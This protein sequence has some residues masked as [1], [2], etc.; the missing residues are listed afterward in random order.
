MQAHDNSPLLKLATSTGPVTN[1]T[2]TPWETDFTGLAEKLKTPTIGAKHGAYFIR[3]SGTR[4][5]DKTVSQTGC[6]IILD[7]D[8]RIDPVTGEVL[9]GAPDPMLVHQVLARLGVPHIL[10]TSHSNGKSKAEVAAD[11]AAEQARH[12]KAIAEGKKHKLT[13][14]NTGGAYGK[15]FHKYRVVIP[16]EVARADLERIVAW[17]I[18]RLHAADVML[19]NVK[20]NKVWPQPWFL[21]RVPDEARLALFR[22]Y[23]TEP[24]L[25]AVPSPDELAT[26]EPE[27]EPAP[28]AAPEP[29]DATPE[30]VFS[31]DVETVAAPGWVSPI[32]MFNER[33]TCAYVLGKADYVGDEVHGWTRP[34]SET[35]Q[36]GVKLLPD[37]TEQ[38]GRQY[39]FS[40]GNDALNDGKPHDAFDCYR[41][42]G[43]DGDRAEAL[44][45]NPELSAANR[46]AL[47][48][49]SYFGPA[50]TPISVEEAMS[51]AL[52]ALAGIKA[53]KEMDP[54][55]LL[56]PKLIGWL[57]VVKHHDAPNW[58]RLEAQ[59]REMTKGKPGLA[60]AIIK[61]VDICNRD[62]KV[63]VEKARA[64][65]MPVQPAAYAYPRTV[66]PMFAVEVVNEKGDVAMR[67]SNVIA[68]TVP[69]Y[70]QGL[71]A[72]D[73]RI[74]MWYLFDGK[75]WALQD[76]THGATGVFVDLLDMGGG[77]K[78]G[79]GADYVSSVTKITEASGRLPLPVFSQSSLPFQNGILDMK[80]GTLAP[81]TPA[82]ALSFVLPYG[83]D[84]AAVY[85][86]IQAWL[87]AA[88]DG[89][90]EMVHFLLCMAAAVLRRIM[91]T[92]G[93]VFLTLVGPGGTGKSTFAKL[94]REL[95][96]AGNVLE[97]TFERLATNKFEGAAIK[98]KLLVLISDSDDWG[99]KVGMLKSLT[100][101]DTIPFERKHQNRSGG[102]ANFV[103]GGAVA[104]LANRP[105]KTEDK[106]SG[107]LRRQR[108]VP[109]NKV[110]T[111]DE[112]ITWQV[113]GGDEANLLPEMPGLVNHL[114][115][116]TEE[117]IVTTLLKPPAGV[118]SANLHASRANDTVADW[119]ICNCKPL[120]GHR[121][122]IGVRK[123]ITL[124]SGDALT[125]GANGTRTWREFEGSQTHLYPNYLTWCQAHEVKY[126]QSHKTFR[127]GVWTALLQFGLQMPPNGKEGRFADMHGAYIPG[128]ALKEAGD[129][130]HHD[131]FHPDENLPEFLE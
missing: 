22:F 81:T 102:A 45:W 119:L 66:H 83:Y 84:P 86:R 130:P 5:S 76:G 106:T 120:D 68:K 79:Y 67:P 112:K 97:T 107:W 65:A 125:A 38:H 105:V 30:W 41:I 87:V 82:N 18:A 15:H 75:R 73:A 127:S 23:A 116:L 14:T 129:H 32:K 124:H 56:D 49:V 31:E 17:L 90:M 58:A 93:Q 110:F 91:G 46:K 77:L 69:T 111:D 118:L 94:L 99:G 53:Q 27:A 59:L 104:V 62:R 40:H 128:I 61:A 109:F 63:A 74:G 24:G 78:A 71:L 85:P 39:V 35:G 37:L 48:A 89:D 51:E 12:D 34:G 88:V 126:P 8:S 100:G 19:A 95:V 115:A 3:A 2:L 9:A 16:C 57:A 122:R 25:W 108:V 60:P 4:R 36:P 55:A 13:L 29:V 64:A 42:L 26:V 131:F 54:G 28:S 7:G 113:G 92:K 11:N 121:A 117:D 80:T 10:Y 43:C 50:E 96:G 72:F 123:E 114:L 1:T 20:E 47:A 44:N 6:A 52:G 98:D 21:P 101:G 70:L 33:F 103:Y